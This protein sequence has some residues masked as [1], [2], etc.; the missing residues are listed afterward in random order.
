[1]MRCTTY[2]LRRSFF[3]LSLFALGR[4]LSAQNEIED[5]RVETYY[6]SDANDATDEVGGTLAVGSRTYRVFVDLG[7]GCSLLGMFADTNHVFTVQST[8]PF[9]NNVDRGKTYGHQVNNNALDENTAALDSWLSFGA[10]SNQKYGVERSADP[11]GSIV[12]GANNDGGSAGI[13]GGLLVNTEGGGIPLTE[14]DG[15]VPLNGGVLP[16]PG[17]FSQGDDPATVFADITESNAFVSNDLNIGCTAPGVAGPLGENVVLVAQLTTAGELSFEL[18]LVILRP[19]GNT[20]RFVA[21]DSILAE[22]EQGFSLLTFPPQCGCTDPSFLEFD[23]SAGCDDGSCTTEIIFGCM[24]TTACNFDANANFSVMQLCCYS[25][26][27]CN[28][29]DPALICPDV[30]VE[31]GPAAPSIQV[32]PNPTRDQLTVQWSSSGKIT[33]LILLDAVGRIS[34]TSNVSASLSTVMMDLTAVAPGSYTLLI[35]QDGATYA[36]SVIRN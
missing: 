28:G 25:L 16:P 9:F 30:S 1:M 6:V 20:V 2:F 3:L 17:F 18:N 32:Y 12:G 24:D 7:E 33:R 22:D 29:L 26:A 14:Q 35:Q 19:D 10:G 8:A 5:I 27:N 13:V 31:D 23:P 34:H 36:R 4:T 15:L 11:D 21:N